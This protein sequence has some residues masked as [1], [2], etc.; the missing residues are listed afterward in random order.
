MAHFRE[1]ETFCYVVEVCERD[2]ACCVVQA[3]LKES[4]LSADEAMRA[5]EE[6]AA[7]LR[8]MEKKVR[9][10]E[11]DLNQA[12]EVSDCREHSQISRVETSPFYTSISLTV[13]VLHTY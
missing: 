7:R 8:D 6:Q 2:C 9:T 1:M 4:N 11:Q 12:Q 10:L 3:Q 5:K 13:S